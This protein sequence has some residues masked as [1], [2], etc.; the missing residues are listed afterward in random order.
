M[1]GKRERV[2]KNDD[3][4]DD[5]PHEEEDYE[6]TVDVANHILREAIAAIL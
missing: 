1:R 6:A 2:P 5:N 3:E 4:V